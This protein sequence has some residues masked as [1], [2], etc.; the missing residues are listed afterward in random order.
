[1]TLSPDL[2]LIVTG[3]RIT[4]PGMTSLLF[5]L[6]KCLKETFAKPSAKKFSD[7]SH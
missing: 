3:L 7:S 1:M 5:G 6:G 2:A 4:L